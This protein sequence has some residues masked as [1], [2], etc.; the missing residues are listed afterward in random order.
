MM[1]EGLFVWVVILITAITTFALLFWQKKNWMPSVFFFV[2]VNFAIYLHFLTDPDAWEGW[3]QL[4]MIFLNIYF[5]IGVLIGH[6]GWF[7]YNFRKN[8]KDAG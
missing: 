6:I 5:F 3:F 2:I 4:A 7:G 1:N 8:N